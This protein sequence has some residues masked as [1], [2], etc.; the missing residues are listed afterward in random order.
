VK[1]KLQGRKLFLAVT[2]SLF[3]IVNIVLLVLWWSQYQMNQT[4]EQTILEKETIVRT[5]EAT[6]LV[7]EPSEKNIATIVSQLPTTDRQPSWINDLLFIFDQ[8]GVTIQNMQYERL[9]RTEPPPTVQMLITN[10]SV[11]GDLTQMR[12]MIEAIQNMDR[13]SHLKEWNLVRITNN[14]YH[15]QMKL[16][17]YYNPVL[18]DPKLELDKP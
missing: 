11:Q 4:L 10:V 16:V 1:M 18:F 5:L 14:Q 7:E 17:T 2:V 6:A 12:K 9:E 8:S 15:Y 3:V 13:V